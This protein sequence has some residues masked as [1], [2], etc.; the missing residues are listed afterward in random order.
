MY[1][2]L[3]PTLYTHV[4][5]R[6]CHTY[7]DTRVRTR[8]RSPARSF[9]R[10]LVRSF[11]RSPTY[12][13]HAHVRGT[14]KETPRLTLP[15]SYSSVGT[16]RLSTVYTTVRQGRG[17]LPPTADTDRERK[18]ERRQVLTRAITREPHSQFDHLVVI[19]PARAKGCE[20]EPQG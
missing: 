18:R 10:S 3:R 7:M 8:T 12:V 2:E 13:G 19:S 17:S 5:K 4:Y 11:A 20:S 6:M 16:T 14:G 1:H 9:A 15:A